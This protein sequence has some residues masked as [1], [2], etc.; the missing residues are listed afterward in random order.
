VASEYQV[1][2]RQATVM[3]RFFIAF[4]L[5]FVGL[6]ANAQTDLSYKNWTDGP[7]AIEDF[8]R[9]TS[10]G[11]LIGECYSGIEAFPSDWE[12]VKWNL[13]VRRL[14]SRTVFDPLKSWITKSD[15]LAGQALRYAQLQFDAT[16]VMRRKMMNY[17]NSGPFNPD[18]AY[19][20][21]RHYDML[22]AY[23]NELEMITEKGRN[24]VALAEQEA[25]MAAQLDSIAEIPDNLPEYGLRKFALGLYA[26]A[27][28]QI[29]VGEYSKYINPGFGFIFGFD[30]VGGR[31]E[32]YLDATLGGG[33][34][35]CKDIPGEKIETWYGGHN[36]RFGETTIQYAYNVYDGNTFKVA[37]FAGFGVGFLDYDNP[38]DDAEIQTDEILGF[39]FLA[40]VSVELK[41]LNSLYLI[42]DLMRSSVYGGINENGIKFK[43]YVTR[44]SYGQGLNPYTVNCAICYDI[45]SKMIKP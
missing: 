10:D 16:E 39:R 9:R 42:G 15:S 35:L 22:S 40:G 7:L 36:L 41:F 6:S 21:R 45:L 20:I 28:S 3:K 1:I 37:P 33:N 13:R 44:T 18:Y 4:V 30:I 5:I 8:A 19:V 32:V 2:G 23:S 31:S 34:R 43:V 24:L 25:V 26:G 27:S 38:D 14:H 11:I 12:K 29:H 17:M